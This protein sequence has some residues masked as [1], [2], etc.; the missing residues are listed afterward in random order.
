M[1]VTAV[2]LGAALLVTPAAWAEERSVH[3]SSW[4]LSS[5]GR[6]VAFK[7][8][9]PSAGE[10]DADLPDV[11]PEG[12]FE[13]KVDTSDVKWAQDCRCFRYYVVNVRSRNDRTV[14][15]HKFKAVP[16]GQFED[17]SV[18]VKLTIKS[19]EATAE[20]DISLP[21]ASAP[22]QEPSPLVAIVKERDPEAVSLGG[23]TDVYFLLSNPNREMDMVVPS[24]VTATADERRLWNETSV[25]TNAAFPLR[26]GPRSSARIRLRLEPKTWEAIQTSLIP[27][28]PTKAHSAFKIGFRYANASFGNR[29]GIAEIPLNVRFRPSILSL[30]ATLALGVFLGSLITM[31]LAAQPLGLWLRSTGTALG[32]ALV[33]EL[34]GIFLVAR[35]SKF[36]VFGL[37][38]DPWQTLPVLLL[39]VGNGLLGLEAAKRLNFVN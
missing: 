28:D 7:P 9:T 35:D 12:H 3:L 4:E 31:L 6:G 38:L 14:T 1:K 22:G 23:P 15:R 21:V 34:L 37:D 18:S 17:Q 33:F 20:E 26:L 24:E 13:F 11:T 10:A 27:S 36:V 8:M 2:V 29:E 30:G 25:S 39:G 32:V 16:N 19:G 5:D